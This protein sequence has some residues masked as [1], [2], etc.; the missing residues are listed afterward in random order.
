MNKLINRIKRKMRVQKEIR[1]KY[2]KLQMKAI[3]VTAVIAAILFVVGIVL[4][5]MEISGTEVLMLFALYIGA[6]LSVACYAALVSGWLYMKRLNGYGY[7]IPENKSDY[8]GK[9][10]NLPKLKNIDATSIYSKHSKWCSRACFLIF[11]IF[12]LFDVSYFLQ[13]K[14]MEENCK[15]LF[16]LC[17]FF[18]LIWLVFALVLKK[19]SNKEKYRDDVEVDATRKER[20]N[21]EQVIFTMLILCLLSLF[22]NSTAHSMTR[23]IFNTMVDHDMVQAD[24]V[25]RGVT[26]ALEEC[27]NV[28]DKESFAELC[29]GIDITTWG[30]P[31][32][33]LQVLIAESMN[34]DD[35]SLM[36]DDF[37]VSDGEAQVYVKINDEKVTVRLL[38]PVKEVLRY[39]TKNK[40][41]YVE[42]DY[43]GLYH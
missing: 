3:K 10:E 29:A 11:V 12:L 4:V 14:F 38:N 28:T 39:S 42:A 34:I 25:R 22:A 26:C 1:I 31:E 6:G 37:K 16:V 7:E 40:E 13:W 27:K 9:I 30:V 43:T 35:F 17:F 23:Y 24:I 32:D 33:E 19:Q 41:I 21:L 18:Y 8:N 2:D 5:Q 15:S 20:W 36:R